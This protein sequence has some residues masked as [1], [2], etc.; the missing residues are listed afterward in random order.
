MSL[1]NILDV[2]GKPDQIDLE[3]LL[4]VMYLL[5]DQRFEQCLRIICQKKTPLK[6]SIISL[7]HSHK[8][9]L[10]SLIE[11]I[12]NVIY[13]QCMSPDTDAS[14]NYWQEF[15][16]RVEEELGDY[17][18]T[19]PYVFF[20]TNYDLIIEQFAEAK[21]KRCIT[22]FED[23]RLAGS[24]GIWAPHTFDNTQRDNVMLHKLHGSLNW[25]REEKTV[26]AESV[27]GRGLRSVSGKKLRNV[28]LYPAGYM[29]LTR[30]P[31]IELLQRLRVALKKTRYL[32]AIGYSFRDPYIQNVIE[33]GF[34]ENQDLQLILIDPNGEKLLKNVLRK[35]KERVIVHPYEF[36]KPECIENFTLGNLGIEK[37]KISATTQREILYFSTEESS[38][39][40]GKGWTVA[41]NDEDIN[42]SDLKE[43][44]ILILLLPERN[45]GLEQ[46]TQRK[47]VD[48]VKEGGK[49][50]ATHDAV[51]T[52]YNSI[53]ATE[54]CGS[55]SGVDQPKEIHV[56]KAKEHQ[57][58]EDI[59]DFKIVDELFHVNTL[60]DTEV[61]LLAKEGEYPI[62]WLR[63][64]HQGEIFYLALGHSPNI[65]ED[66][67][68]QKIILNAK[69]WL[70][71]EIWKI[72]ISN[73]CSQ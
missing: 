28:I 65:I 17:L 29:E 4:T 72:K 41:R 13:E 32:V 1:L 6:D 37:D 35:I 51:Y 47:I 12:Q 26:R 55:F 71:R 38:F 57:I 36:G 2:S 49:L 9:N 22:G 48:Y 30:E 24:K 60:S 20:T 10:P 67:N 21:R 62:A 7:Y 58:T 70:M 14:T 40:K 3:E 25:Y 18:P 23:N 8:E 45:R 61:L 16:E 50:I 69:D 73:S 42:R 64:Y 27:L 52:E 39:E 68:V 43:Y 53:L 15:L 59:E 19:K 5:R 11:E 44:D 34:D 66:E 56:T 46:R 54:L 33:S 31:F 63:K